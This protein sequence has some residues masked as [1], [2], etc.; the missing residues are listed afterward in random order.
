MCASESL[1]LGLSLLLEA[2]GMQSE[3]KPGLAAEENRGVEALC[4]SHFRRMSVESYALCWDPIG[5]GR[6]IAWFDACTRTL[7]PI[8]QGGRMDSLRGMRTVASVIVGSS[9][10]FTPVSRAAEEG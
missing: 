7:R 6:F 3:S 5:S 1:L 9:L 8:N 4:P 2:S 10:S